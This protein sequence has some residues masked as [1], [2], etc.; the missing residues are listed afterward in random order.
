M[1]LHLL[2]VFWMQLSNF[3]W[4]YGRLSS[5]RLW[6]MYLLT[7]VAR[8]KWPLPPCHYLTSFVFCF[9][10]EHWNSIGDS[11][12]LLLVLAPIISAHSVYCIGVYPC[13]ACTWL[14]FWTL[15]SFL[16]LLKSWYFFMY[17]VSWYLIIRFIWIT[18]VYNYRLCT[19]FVVPDM[20]LTAV[21]S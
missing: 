3:S 16:F 13:L 4:R 1:Y 18:G 7:L 12:S 19:F 2:C 6:Y 11:S 15:S 9:A 21:C 5:A 17:L 20:H 14:S 10:S 8:L